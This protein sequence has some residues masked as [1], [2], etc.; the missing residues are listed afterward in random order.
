MLYFNVLARDCGA[1][2][3]SQYYHS[4]NKRLN[5]CEISR[6]TPMTTW[7]VLIAPVYTCLFVLFMSECLHMAFSVNIS[8]PIWPLLNKILCLYG[9]DTWLLGYCEIKILL[10]VKIVIA[11]LFLPMCEDRTHIKVVCCHQEANFLKNLRIKQVCI[12]CSSVSSWKGC[13][14]NC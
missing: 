9:P 4:S 5:E 12:Y 7:V 13:A 10:H 14:K 8:E 11:G 3:Q 6:S 1:N 2:S